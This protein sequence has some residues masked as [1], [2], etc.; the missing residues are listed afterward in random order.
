MFLTCKKMIYGTFISVLNASFKLKKHSF[1]YNAK[2]ENM[3]LE[4]T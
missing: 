1:V 3:T 2:N 4:L